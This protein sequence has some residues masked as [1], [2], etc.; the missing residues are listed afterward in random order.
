MSSD[1][2]LTVYEPLGRK[3]Q[4]SRQRLPGEHCF[5]V[6]YVH[7]ATCP[8]SAWAWSRQRAEELGNEHDPA[9]FVLVPY[10]FTG[11]LD[12]RR[13]PIYARDWSGAVDP[14]DV[15]ALERRFRGER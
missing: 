8:R 11:R 9:D 3:T 1:F 13:R 2:P 5:G 15:E 14:L 10:H 12:N 6:D 7:R 4:S